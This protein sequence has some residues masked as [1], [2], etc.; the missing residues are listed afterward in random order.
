MQK[1]ITITIIAIII[2]ASGAAITWAI[3][4]TGT[5]PGDQPTKQKILTQYITKHRQVKQVRVIHKKAPA[6]VV[7]TAATGNAA[8]NQSAAAAYAQPAPVAG[9]AAPTAPVAA[10]PVVQPRQQEDI[11][12]NESRSKKLDQD[13]DH[14][15]GEEQDG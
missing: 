14:E 6:I 3:L 1:P 7:G 13:K 9:R 10:Q 2:V 15:D 12:E 5:L 4:P 11:Q 8:S